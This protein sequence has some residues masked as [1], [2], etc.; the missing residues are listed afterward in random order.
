MSAKLKAAIGV[1]LIFVG[2]ATICFG[3]FMLR[4]GSEYEYGDV[5]IENL[6]DAGDTV[7]LEAVSF[8]ITAKQLTDAAQMEIWA[9]VS[10]EEAY[11]HA[12]K[13]LVEKYAMY[14]MATANGI[15]P[16]EEAVQAEI[17]Y[18]REI[19]ETASN[20]ENFRSFL[21]HIGMTHDEYWDSQYTNFS[22][23][24]AIDQF[25]QKLKSDFI[26]SGKSEMD[27]EN[28]YNDFV[29]DTVKKEKIKV[30]QND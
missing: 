23:Y 8:S 21:D 7:V 29:A 4:A 5:K 15:V 11:A 3:I 25:K 16:D 12:E 14:R 30:V 28:Y 18:N 6:T 27:W 2:M 22:E 13:A 24:D 19:S 10:E 9:G 20:Y 17:E 26:G 1:L